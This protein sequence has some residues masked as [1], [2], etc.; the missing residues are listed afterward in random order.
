MYSSVFA[1]SN[2]S[3]VEGM[4]SAVQIAFSAISGNKMGEESDVFDQNL[5]WSEW[6]DISNSNKYLNEYFIRIPGYGDVAIYIEPHGNTS[7]I[8][9]EP[10][11]ESEVPAK[12]I[13]KVASKAGR[14]TAA[15]LYSIT[16]Q[17]LKKGIEH[18]L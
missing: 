15:C 3:K 11:S 2:L 16:P 14:T 8:Y 12:E 6:F 18:S 5:S 4:E 13:I 7:H 17:L 10:I 9:I 1:S